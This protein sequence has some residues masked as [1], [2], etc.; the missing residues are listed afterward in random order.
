MLWHMQ[1]C[2]IA[3]HTVMQYAVYG[4]GRQPVSVYSS[5]HRKQARKTRRRGDAATGLHGELRTFYC[6]LPIAYIA[7]FFLNNQ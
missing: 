3:Q 7:F 5:T 6:L 4:D 1:S 2:S